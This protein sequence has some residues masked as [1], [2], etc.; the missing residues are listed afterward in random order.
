[1]VENEVMRSLEQSAAPGETG[2]DKPRDQ[3]TFPPLP[4]DAMIT[5]S[6]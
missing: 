4:A 2:P 3:Q 6:Q 1:V 5:T